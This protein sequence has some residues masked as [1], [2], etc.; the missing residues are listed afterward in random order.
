MFFGGIKFAV[1]TL[2]VLRSRERGRERVENKFDRQ[3]KG[4]KSALKEGA[5]GETGETLCNGIAVDL[6]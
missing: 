5:K 3:V 4:R 6:Q 1:T 2:N